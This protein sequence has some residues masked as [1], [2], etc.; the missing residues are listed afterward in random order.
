MLSCGSMFWQPSRKKTVS[1]VTTCWEKDWRSILLD[2]NYLQT[3]Q[4]SPHGFLF[5]EKILI[6]NNVENIEEVVKAA[7]KKVQ[8]NILTRFVVAPQ[9]ENDVFS[10]FQLE[11]KD[12]HP[13]ADACLYENV[14]AKWLYYN[15]LAPLTALYVVQSDY[16]LYLTG[17]VTLTKPVRWIPQ[18]LRAM[19]KNPSFKVANLVWNDQYK[20]ANQEAYRKTWNFFVAKQGFSDQMFLLHCNTFKQPIYKEIR[21]DS[22]H[23]PRGDVWEKRVF[24]CMKNRGW[25]RITY[26]R[27]SYKHE[28]F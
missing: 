26:R 22:S 8:E 16:M 1:F 20:E 10:F 12:F 11:E 3:R 23:Y 24:S 13:G 19:E 15:A 14:H 17:D 27:G 18:A 9:I 6:I 28:N 5:Q 25:E 2:P 21:A 7:Q 4:I